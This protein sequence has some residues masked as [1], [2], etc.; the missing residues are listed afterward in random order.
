MMRSFILRLG[1]LAERIMAQ[2]ASGWRERCEGVRK[3]ALNYVQPGKQLLFN[4]GI[5]HDRD[6]IDESLASLRAELP[7]RLV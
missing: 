4:E 3:D 1:L 5:N 7:L 6:L 2:V